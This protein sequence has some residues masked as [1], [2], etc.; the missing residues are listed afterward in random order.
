[1][2]LHNFK[3]YIILKDV[4]KLYI[5]RPAKMRIYAKFAGLNFRIKAKGIKILQYDV[6][7]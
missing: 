4:A 1:M 7:P 6:E 3:S 2:K 5:P